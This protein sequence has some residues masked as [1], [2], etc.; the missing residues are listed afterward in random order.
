MRV[1]IADDEALTRMG[2][3]TMLARWVTPSSVQP[4]MESPHCDGGE[5]GPTWLFWTSKCREWTVCCGR[6]YRRAI[7]STVVMLLPTVST[8]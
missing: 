4:L 2:L 5:T 8:I 3:Q 6:G 1:L 7:P